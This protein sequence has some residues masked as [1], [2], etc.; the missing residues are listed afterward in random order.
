M[1]IIE[2]K[3]FQGS[4]CESWAMSVWFNFSQERS[5]K[6]NDFSSCSFLKKLW[7]IVGSDWF[8]SI[9]WGDAG[10]SVVI[11]EKKKKNLQKGSA[12]K[13]RTSANF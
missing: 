3:V 1:S 7:K 8:H 4:C 10:N 12:G 6:G 5:G 11:A 2:E 9:W 13:K